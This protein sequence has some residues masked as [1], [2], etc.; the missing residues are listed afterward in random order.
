MRWEAAGRLGAFCGG[1]VQSRNEVQP[2]EPAVNEKRDR[3]PSWLIHLSP[4]I[5]GMMPVFVALLGVV[6]ALLLPLVV[7]FRNWFRP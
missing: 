5:I 4:S 6:I 3:P 1:K 2:A 7:V